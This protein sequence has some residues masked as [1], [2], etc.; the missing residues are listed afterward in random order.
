MP[1]LRRPQLSD[2]L[3]RN[4][5]AYAAL[6]V[7]LGGTSWAAVN[8]PRNSVGAGQL[9]TNAVRSQEIARN[10]VR[11][12]EVRN[13]SLRRVDLARGVLTRG[14]PGVAGA[15]GPPGPPGPPGAAG[16]PGPAG[17]TG[18]RGPS[19]GYFDEGEISLPQGTYL[20]HGAGGA[21]NNGGGPVVTTCEFVY[22]NAT[23]GETGRAQHSLAANETG[24][25]AVVGWVTIG[26]G[27]GS[28]RVDCSLSPTVATEFYVTATQVESI[29]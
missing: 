22:G 11:S 24:A 17:Q 23:G 15:I 14:A 27:G 25:L 20:V 13:R 5:V 7:A 16:A 3:R 9:R 12:A 29:G 26:A 8:L 19:N 6:F 4:T 1:K 28:A 10:A 2:H 21:I 18:P